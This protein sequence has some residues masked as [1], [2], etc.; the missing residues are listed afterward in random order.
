MSDD[1]SSC[2]AGGILLAFIAGGLVGAGFA[3]LYAPVSGREARERIGGLAEDLRKKSD[4]WSGEVK[5]KVDG[6][7]D[8]ERS[9]IKAAYDAGRDAMTKEKARFENPAPNP[10]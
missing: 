10:E 9:V 6:F 8:E 2:D 7:I 3:L 5:R 4:E 1:R